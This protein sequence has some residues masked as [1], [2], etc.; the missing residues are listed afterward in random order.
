MTGVPVVVC[1]AGIDYDWAGGAPVGIAVGVDDFSVRWTQVAD[2]VEG[3]YE[4]T[5][6]S[7]DG[8]RVLVDGSAVIDNWTDHA[9]ATDSVRMSMTGGPHTVVVEYYENG[10]SAVAQANYSAS[11]APD[12]AEGEWT[13]EYFA[14]KL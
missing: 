8:V 10:G 3:T 5:T 13:A 1:E 11:S 4:F 14:N 6:T 7:D 9:V 2:L 12:C